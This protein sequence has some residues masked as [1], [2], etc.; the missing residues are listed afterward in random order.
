VTKGLDFLF[1][2][3]AAKPG[4]ELMMVDLPKALADFIRDGG[5]TFHCDDGDW[6]LNIIPAEDSPFVND[7]PKRSVVIAENG[8]G[9]CLF[10]KRTAKGSFGKKVLVFWHEENRSEEFAPEVAALLKEKAPVP[11]PSL[12]EES[13]VK[14]ITLAEL[15]KVVTD[16]KRGSYRAEVMRRFKAGAFGIEAL[17][18][19]RAVLKYDDILLATEAIE[20]I[21]KL[22][23]AVKEVDD[24]D[25]LQ[26]ELTTVGS[27]VW[28]Y[29]GYANAYSA[30]LET[31]RKIEGDETVIL[32]YVSRNVGIECPDDFLASLRALK[33]IGSKAALDLLRRAA[34]F[35]APD[36]NL[37][38]RKE[39]ERILNATS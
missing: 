8:C 16:P 32:G 38:Q 30:C 39:M 31:L 6:D 33:T 23:A 22:G 17:P 12:M 35:R 24:F 18:F 4:A 15:E 36:L 19:L 20:C 11:G 1:G 3:I 9:D 25:W 28:D 5:V 27:K 26:H 13:P 7:L 37:R 14:T 29:S 2:D 34:A 10:L 21:G